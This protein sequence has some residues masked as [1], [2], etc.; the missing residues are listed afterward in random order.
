MAVELLVDQ[1]SLER[2]GLIDRPCLDL[3][4]FLA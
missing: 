4:E 2:R 3:S 1:R